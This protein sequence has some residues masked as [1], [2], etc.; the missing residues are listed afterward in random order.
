MS[1]VSVAFLPKGL[2]V[3]EERAVLFKRAHAPSQHTS[4]VTRLPC[5]VPPSRQ[6][7]C[8]IRPPTSRRRKCLSEHF[9]FEVHAPDD[10]SLD[11]DILQEEPATLGQSGKWRRY[12]PRM[13]A[14]L[15]SIFN[16]RSRR[17]SGSAASGMPES[18]WHSGY[19]HP[20][21]R[22][23]A[24]GWCFCVGA[25]LDCGQVPFQDSSQVPRTFNFKINWKNVRFNMNDNF[26]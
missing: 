5:P 22:S 13:I 24:K 19:I 25:N 14:P 17:P 4:E 15:T 9:D 8:P 20:G 1:L 11:T 21:Y 6:F 18:R 10:V 7:Q 26:K 23:P 2:L 12:T 3:K 16:K